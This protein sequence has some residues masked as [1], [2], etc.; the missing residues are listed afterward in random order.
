MGIKID[1]SNNVVAS[2]NITIKTKEALQAT[3][4]N[5]AMRRIDILYS[6]WK[7]KHNELRRRR[8]KS[9]LL[10]V[11]I[12]LCFSFISFL[13]NVFAILIFGMWPIALY[14]IMIGRKYQN[15]EHQLTD[16]N[17]SIQE[18]EDLIHKEHLYNFARGN[19]QLD[20]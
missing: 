8:T 17:I 9:S 18:T 4:Y 19:C 2:G 10:F 12:I 1:G 20:A 6:D 5:E 3:D 13:T 16:Y 15:E 11:A 14:A 7:Y